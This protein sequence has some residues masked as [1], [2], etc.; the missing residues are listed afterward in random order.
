MVLDE[1]ADQVGV[2]ATQLMPLTKGFSDP[3]PKLRMIAPLP[4]C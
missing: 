1:P 4:F 3:D 2:P